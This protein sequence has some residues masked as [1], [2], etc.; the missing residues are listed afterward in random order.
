LLCFG[1]VVPSHNNASTWGGGWLVKIAFQFYFF[2]LPLGDLYA[3]SPVPAW[4]G[5]LCFGIC[6]DQIVKNL[7]KLLQNY[8]RAKF[9]QKKN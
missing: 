6:L 2:G 9:L 3:N 1:T 5:K 8:S 4:S 7:T